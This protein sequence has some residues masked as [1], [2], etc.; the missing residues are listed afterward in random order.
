MLNQM[1]WVRTGLAAL[2]AIVFMSGLVLAKKP[3]KDPPPEPDPPFAYSISWFSP[4]PGD[5]RTCTAGMNNNGVVVGKSYVE[6]VPESYG[7][8][9][10]Y[11]NTS[12]V[13]VM[14]DLNDL[15][16]DTDLE[17]EFGV[18]YVIYSG[19]DVNDD[20][21]I[22]GGAWDP[23]VGDSSA[24][25]YRYTPGHGESP[26][27][28]KNL[29]L[30]INTE[31]GFY[32][33]ATGINDSGNVIGTA[34]NA[35]TG[36]VRGFFYSDADG[37][38]DIGDLGGDNVH[39]RA[40]NN[41]GQVVGYDRFSIGGAVG[42]FYSVNDGTSEVSTDMAYAMGLYSINDSGVV[43]G[44]GRFT[45]ALNKNRTITVS[46]PARYNCATGQ[47]DD[48]GSLLG[49]AENSVAYGINAHGDMV[50]DRDS[51]L[52]PWVY[53]EKFGVLNL[54]QLTGYDL[55]R[56]SWPLKINDEVDIIGNERLTN[57]GF[58]LIRHD[59]P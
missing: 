25:A 7:G 1:K 51:N 33:Y 27:L 15:V 48:L 6:D 37:M 8:F 52:E 41:S 30:P 4:L 53:I 59:L 31:T 21:Q 29:G 49:L 44:W 9:I 14:E 13:R 55:G 45:Y 16:D 24:R 46:N 47:M 50:G 3:P 36:V 12:G 42:F 54:N 43:V 56:L 20:G 22:V 18:G 28:L 26:P 58:L 19:E 35:D 10:S 39:P 23:S 17:S 11:T 5:D 38:Q 57:R 34:R 2:M 32:S 40:I